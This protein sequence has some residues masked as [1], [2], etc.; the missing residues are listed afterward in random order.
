MAKKANNKFESVIECLKQLHDAIKEVDENQETESGDGLTQE[1][2]DT[3]SLYRIVVG[4][5]SMWGKFWKF[6]RPT[7]DSKLEMFVVKHLSKEKKHD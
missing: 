5:C 6:F 2:V 4:D 3:C 1:Q 7:G